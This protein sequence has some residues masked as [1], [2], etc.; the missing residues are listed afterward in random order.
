[1]Y[2]L[3]FPLIKFYPV[4]CSYFPNNVS[5]ARFL[6]SMSLGERHEGYIIRKAEKFPL[7][8]RYLL[9]QAVLNPINMQA[10]YTGV[11]LGLG[12]K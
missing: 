11:D 6:T 12:P 9:I 2:I 10:S 5:K 4:S 1:M 7:R 3:I 8:I